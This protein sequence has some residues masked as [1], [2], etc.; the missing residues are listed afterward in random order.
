M[1]DGVGDFRH[2][3]AVV[4]R[5]G[6]PVP[7]HAGRDG[8]ASQGVHH[9]PAQYA[10]HRYDRYPRAEAFLERRQEGCRVLFA[11][12]QEPARR[13]LQRVGIL[14]AVGEE[15]IYPSLDE[16]LLRAEE[17]LEEEKRK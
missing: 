11:A 1:P 13:T 2:Q 10:R 15:N 3:R 14:R 9:V 5:G 16:A 17:I 7:V 12:V 4:L 8:D 6:R